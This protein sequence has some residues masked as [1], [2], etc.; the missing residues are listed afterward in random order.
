MHLTRKQ[1]ITIIVPIAA[2]IV[3]GFVLFSAGLLFPSALPQT[4]YTT[5]NDI[6]VMGTGRSYG[7]SPIPV[8]VI[9]S[10]GFTNSTKVYHDKLP[11]LFEFVLK[12]NSSGNITM[13]Y[14]FSQNTSTTGNDGLFDFFFGRK[15]TPQY[16]LAN[17]YHQNMS[18]YFGNVDIS[19]VTGNSTTNNDNN[20]N[21]VFLSR[22]SIQGM[23][24][25]PSNISNV[26]DRVVKVTYTVKTDDSVKE[27]TYLLELNIYPGELV[28]IGNAP[29]K[30]PLPWDN[31]TL[32]Y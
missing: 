9:D 28:T 16:V 31:S 25:Y 7:A 19:Q 11:G 27:G 21:L 2:A 15:G 4:P 1:Q 13:L 6:A 8:S 23:S 22:N 14:D 26:T 30:M 5:E 3:V 17:I 32:R 18:D 29:A 20:S 10:Q 24:V 12:P